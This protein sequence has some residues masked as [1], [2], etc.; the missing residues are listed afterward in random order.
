MI[1]DYLNK[2]YPVHGFDSR[3]FSPL[4]KD[5]ISKIMEEQQKKHKYITR[6]EYNLHGYWCRIYRLGVNKC[7]ADSIFGGKMEALNAALLW[8]N[9]QIGGILDE[10]SERC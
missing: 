10:E 5:S 7:F 6:K 8:R 4:P 9:K 2:Y 1:S 3:L